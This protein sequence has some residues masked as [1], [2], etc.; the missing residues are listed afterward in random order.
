MTDSG[1]WPKDEDEGGDADDGGGAVSDSSPGAARG[2]RRSLRASAG[3]SVSL[4]YDIEVSRARF[5]D[6]GEILGVECD[7]LVPAALENQITLANVD[8]VRCK[9]L[10]EA[11]NGPT[12]PAAEERLLRRGV[13][14]LPD[15]YL[16]A[17][18]VTVSYF[19]WIKNIGH[20]RF[21][22]MAKRIDSARD[23]LL[24]HALERATGGEMSATQHRILSRGRDE[25]DLVR[26]GLEGTMVDAYREIRAVYK[27]KR[28]VSDLRTAAYAVAIEKVATA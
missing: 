13:L 27:R 6:P 2:R 1:E 26:S 14:V 11:A 21:G 20:M 18:G 28:K 8:Q 4:V 15:I 9:V 17:G 10:A 12:T 25:I 23:D 3:D 16:N 24:L 7:V 5:D 22:R 19:E